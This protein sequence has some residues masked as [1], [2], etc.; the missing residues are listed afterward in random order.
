MEVNPG[1]PVPSPP[2]THHPLRLPIYSHPYL[3][4]TTYASTPTLIPHPPTATYANP[5][6]LIP[7]L[8]LPS[9]TILTPTHASPLPHTPT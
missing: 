3:P 1:P 4:A 6:T 8:H 7:L 9:F 2:P 5:P